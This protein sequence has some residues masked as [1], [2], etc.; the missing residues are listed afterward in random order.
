[1][2]N[3]LRLQNY[4]VIKYSK[5]KKEYLEKRKKETAHRMY[6]FILLNCK[7]RRNPAKV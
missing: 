5:K 2:I 4:D 6:F 1:M 3:Y 7:G